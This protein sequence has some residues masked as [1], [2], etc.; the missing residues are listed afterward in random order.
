MASNHRISP[1]IFISIVLTIYILLLKT[2]NCSAECIWINKG[3]G[4]TGY[5]LTSLAIDRENPNIIYVGTKGFLFKTNDFGE[6][7][8]DIFKV[9]G[10]NKAVNFLA[11]DPKDSETIYIATESGIF[12]SEDG[13]INW[14]AIPFGK[15]DNAFTLLIDS[16]NKDTLF[17]GAGG[18]IFITK[19]RG[20]NWSISSEGL[21]AVNI[22]SIAQNYIDYETLFAAAENGLFKSED[23]GRN[24]KKIFSVDSITDEYENTYSE[25]GTLSNSTTW[26]SVDSFNP[27]VIYLST[28]DGIFKSEDNGDSWMRLPKI[29]P[30]SAHI[31]N[32]VLPSYNRGFIFAATDEGVFRFSEEENMW[33]EFA[34]G[35]NSRMAVFMALNPQQGALWLAT[36]NRIYK[37]KGD[38]YEIKE[39]SLPEK[40][41]TI[42][43]N[44]S[45]EPGYQEVQKRAIEY[46]EVHPEKIAKWRRAAKR[47]ALL[48]RLSFGIDR[49][50]SKEIHW[51]TTGSDTWIV[52]P[53]EEDTGWD[54]T[55]TWDLGELVWNNDQTLIDVRSKLMVQLRDDVLDEVT[56]LYFERRRLQI[57]L[58][59]DPPKDVG[60]L[61][62]KELR[63]QELTAD[64]DAMTGGW[65]SREIE[66][67]KN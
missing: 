3:D 55:C 17:A 35:L 8:K 20:R 52:G 46:A 48:P 29:G 23:K 10:I 63:L 32:L 47:K 61:I 33:K 15:G 44:F 67:R 39:I 57:E 49:D 4:L 65:F 30:S 1:K 28:K 66:R 56:H 5:K 6:N 24:W 45:S 43:Q 22:K 53:D 40:A 2:I 64:I 60:E 51:D 12:K 14:Q 50:K 41:K 18:D 26:V 21:S 54:I 34:S 31:K 13:G 38:I 58:M 42:L 7:W 19:D 62:N 27:E 11:I 9:P 16:E 37:S 25:G 36:E 59:Q